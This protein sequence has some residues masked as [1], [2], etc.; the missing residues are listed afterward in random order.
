MMFR[1]IS[2]MREITADLAPMYQS[3]VGQAAPVIGVIRVDS[4][5]QDLSSPPAP[6][7]VGAHLIQVSFSTWKDLRAYLG[8]LRGI[9][10]A[11]MGRRMYEEWCKR[12]EQLCNEKERLLS[13]CGPLLLEGQMNS[14]S[15]NAQDT[16]IDL[17]TPI[18]DNSE[19]PIRNVETVPSTPRQVNA[20]IVGVLHAGKMP[21]LLTCHTAQTLTT[22]GS[23]MEAAT[24][25]LLPQIIVQIELALPSHH[26]DAMFSALKDELITWR[27]QR[28]S[29]GEIRDWKWLPSLM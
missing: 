6:S 2:N 15:P 20:T 14:I 27:K 17:L 4:F 22:W 10:E 26:R 24:A 13:L 23:E 25:L 3:Q 16:L 1:H 28:P 5:I 11:S 29:V 9:A 7:P 12:I 19:L 8:S 21:F 18:I